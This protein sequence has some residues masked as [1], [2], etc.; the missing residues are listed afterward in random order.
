MITPAD[1]RS[2]F[3]FESLTDEQ[4]AAL[5]D[6]GEEVTFGADDVLFEEGQPADHLWVLVEGRIPLYRRTEHE[7]T[8]LFAMERPGQWGGGFRAWHSE[9]SYLATARAATPGR[10]FK[11]SAGALSDLAHEWFP[12]G[13]HLI[14]G[15][16]QTVR[17]LEALNREQEKFVALGTIAASLAH[18]LNNPAAA[19]SQAVAELDYTCLHMFEALEHLA[20]HE[21]RA[22]EFIELDALRKELADAVPIPLDP[23]ALADR[24]EQLSDWLEGQGVAGGWR[25]GSMIASSGGDIDWCER[26]AAAIGRD[27][28]EPGLDWVASA[29]AASTLLREMRESTS[30]ISGLVNSTRLYTQ[31]DRATRQS[32]DVVE[33]IENTLTILR[34]R[35]G[36]GVEVVREYDDAM[37]LIDGYPGELNQVWTNLIANA[38]D[39][40]HS[41]GTLKI[42]VQTSDGTVIVDITDSGAGMPAEVQAR[43]FEPFFTTKDVGSGTGLGLDI[44]RQIVKDRHHGHIS[45]LRSAPGETVIRVRL[46]IA[47]G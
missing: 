20:T 13:V 38:I 10:I 4:I 22:A 11:I 6:R 23:L 12:F 21:L 37:P 44:S 8:M 25:I 39:A 26:V 16:F 46:P 36:A 35:M 3:L 40:M 14:E 41:S 18:E 24:E 32:L 15:I 28:L 42:G 7:E 29:L 17:R 45:I 27:R 34:H 1:L 9:A 5:I 31:V 47:R 43:A 33:G 19:A 30:R 2:T